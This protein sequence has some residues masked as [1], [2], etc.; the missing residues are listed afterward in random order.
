[1]QVGDKVR[2]KYPFGL[3]F[4][5]VYTTVAIENNVHYLEGIEGGFDIQYLEAV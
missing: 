5:D 2:V 4:Q 3:T 1:M